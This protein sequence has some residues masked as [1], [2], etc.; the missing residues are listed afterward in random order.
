MAAVKGRMNARP[1]WQE[2]L[3]NW[4]LFSIGILA[5]SAFFAVTLG[6]TD[7][8]PR[9]AFKFLT[10]T[11]AWSALVTSLWRWRRRALSAAPR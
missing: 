2:L 7:T 4:L 3:I 6:W 1:Q 9:N 10:I 11:F 8:V 5:S